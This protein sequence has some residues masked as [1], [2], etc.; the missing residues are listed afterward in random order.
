LP[1]I[2]VIEDEP[3]IQKLARVNLTTSGYE[4]LI[5]ANGE[6]GLR[7]AE[8]EKPDLILL[9]LMLPGMSGWEVLNN[10]RAMP[11]VEKAPVVIIIT[12]A[13]RQGDA[14]K[15]RAMGA[16]GYLAKPFAADELLME[17]KKVLG[18]EAQ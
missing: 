12:A 6:E 4:V 9:D 2:L 7:L 1:K 18:G 16:A 3:N 13:V 8:A 15:A 14:E 5:A 10:L 11:D 17:V